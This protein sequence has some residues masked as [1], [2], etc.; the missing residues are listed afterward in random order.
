MNKIAVLGS[1]AKAA[2]N[3]ENS[4]E[5]G[6]INWDYVSADV[7]L[8]MKPATK[9]ESDFVD[10]ML[11]AFADSYERNKGKSTFRPNYR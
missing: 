11:E 9:E 6:T 4:H 7:Y 5:D 2:C 10:M 8:D 1:L 3:L